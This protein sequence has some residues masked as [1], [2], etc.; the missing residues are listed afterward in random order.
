MKLGTISASSSGT[1]TLEY[2]PQYVGIKF[3]TGGTL[4]SVT[5]TTDEGTICNLN[6]DAVKAIAQ[7]FSFGDLADADNVYFVPLAA[8][9]IGNKKCTVYV[10]TGA[11]GTGVD[12]YGTSVEKAPHPIIFNSYIFDV[13]A[14]GNTEINKFTKFGI[15]GFANTD[16]LTYN[17]NSGS[18]DRLFLEEIRSIASFDY[19]NQDDYVI[20]NND[21]AD[22]KNIIYSPSANRTCWLIQM[23]MQGSKSL[24]DI[25]EKVAVRELNAPTVS[26]AGPDKAKLKA[27]ESIGNKLRGQKLIR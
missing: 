15:I 25:I 26:K 12:L 14:N 21:D 23:Q 7:S 19:D 27:A 17:S 4:D 20:F 13:I 2:V 3:S 6:G 1:F 24:S 18:S 11:G 5:V 10:S 8:G 16:V 22:I 9:Y